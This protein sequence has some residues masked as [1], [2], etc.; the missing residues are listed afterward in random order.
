[1]AS[2]LGDSGSSGLVLSASAVLSEHRLGREVA[3][4]LKEDCEV[5]VGVLKASVDLQEE[6][7]PISDGPPD[8]QESHVK[9]I[10]FL[11]LCQSFSFD[12]VRFQT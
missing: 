11:L 1:M 3:L 5:E 10:N 8:T 2:V 12:L 7:P 4:N 9:K 6:K